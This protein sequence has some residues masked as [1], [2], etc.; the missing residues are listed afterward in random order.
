MYTCL[1]PTHFGYTMHYG[2]VLLQAKMVGTQIYTLIIVIF[3]CIFIC[4]VQ[5]IKKC[6]L[7]TDQSWQ[8][9]VVCLGRKHSK[10]NS[11]LMIYV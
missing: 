4:V 6:S 1:S 8:F 5:T 7:S 9:I 3:K 2:D 10:A 11:A